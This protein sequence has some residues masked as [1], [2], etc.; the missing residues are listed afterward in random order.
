MFNPSRDDARRFFFATWR[1]HQTHESLTDLE[2]ITLAI[3]LAHPEYHA[4]LEQPEHYLTHDWHPEDGATNPF[5]HWSMH[6]SIEEQ[7]SIDQPH[8]LRALYQRLCERYGEV[9]SAQ[10]AVMDGLAEMIW[11][12]Q[13]SASEPDPTVYLNC[14]RRQ[15]GEN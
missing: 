6:L 1:K 13:R 3:L 14:L 7:L 2:R 8:G 10:H 4:V 5:L 15:L 9:H 12:A 11:Q